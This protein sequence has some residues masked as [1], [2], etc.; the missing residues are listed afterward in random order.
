MR[1]HQIADQFRDELEDLPGTKD[2]RL[3]GYREREF[4]VKLNRKK[5]DQ[6]HVAVS[7][8][9]QKLESRNI[10]VPGGNVEKGKEQDLV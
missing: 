7:E 2:V 3:T 6:L 1:K 9:L 8:V 4:T 5:M 10:S